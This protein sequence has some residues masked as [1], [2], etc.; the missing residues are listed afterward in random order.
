MMKLFTHLF[1]LVL[2][3][4]ST[5]R[6]QDGVTKEDGTKNA[7]EGQNPPKDLM[8]STPTLLQRTTAISSSPSSSEKP[9]SANSTDHTTTA[10]MA[11]ETKPTSANPTN[12]SEKM[13]RGGLPV[14]TT[15]A[16]NG[17][18]VSSMTASGFVTTPIST[19]I[20]SE[21][22]TEDE[23]EYSSWGYVILVLFALVIITLF[24]IL[25]YLRRGSRT[26]SFDL[27]RPCPVNQLSGT[28]HTGTFEQVYLD[29]LSVPTD[30]VTC[31]EISPAPVANGTS[32]QSEDRGLAEESAPQDLAPE[33]PPTSDGDLSLDREQ[34]GSTD[35]FFNTTGEEQQ[36]NNPSPCSTQ[37]FVEINL[38]EPALCDHLLISPEAPSS[39]LP[40]SSFSLSTSSL[41]S[42]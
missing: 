27:H 39:V 34:L 12:E 23:T 1:F 18:A 9:T 36:N 11:R 8:S 40:F 33:T 42:T 3:V 31:D 30:K 29:D 22:E 24:V 21:K 2:M 14:M 26:Y 19:G 25:Y 35:G 38:D 10:Y 41:S 32:L 6:G 37:P 17:T 28:E 15:K 20:A 13:G 5:A 7:N 4:S 16:T